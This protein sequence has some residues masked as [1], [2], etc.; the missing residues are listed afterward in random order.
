MSCKKR[1]TKPPLI[2]N[3]RGIMSILVPH[4]TSYATKKILHLIL[5]VERYD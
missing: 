1:G 3:K 4:K 5:K 2:Q